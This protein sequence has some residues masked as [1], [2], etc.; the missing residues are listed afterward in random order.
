MSAESV[1]HMYR[2]SVARG[3]FRAHEADEREAW[4]PR[5][6][7]VVTAI[8][9]Y[10]GIGGNHYAFEESCRGMG[11]TPKVLINVEINDLANLTYVQNFGAQTKLRQAS[12]ESIKLAELVKLK[13]DAWLA[14]PPCQPYTRAGLM[15]GSADPR[16]NSFFHLLHV[17][18]TMH[19][20]QRPGLLFVE[21]VKN[22]E[23]S[24]TRDTLV[25]ILSTLG[26]DTR[27]HLVNPNQVG[28]PNSRLRYF[29]IGRR[30]QR[31][32]GHLRMGLIDSRL[33]THE[34]LSCPQRAVPTLAEVLPHIAAEALQECLLTQKQI[35]SNLTRLMDLVFP[36]SRGTMCFTKGYAQYFEGTGSF[37]CDGAASREDAKLLIDAHTAH[38]PARDDGAEVCPLMALRIRRLAPKEI[39]SLMSFPDSFTF[40]PDA[41]LRQQYRLL[42]NSVSVAV[43]TLVIT[44]LLKWE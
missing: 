25:S 19:H 6:D 39:S 13:A 3:E 9:F 27:E 26:Y 38:C 5:A 10:S 12:I 32:D 29:L 11:L 21:N 23:N 44:E 35:C 22:F 16:A 33:R 18:K 28:I 24:D 41:T 15:K 42:G 37:M 2:A 20:S 31:S 40:H 17:L 34:D 14:S 7:G 1:G 8:D 30:M 4:A 36:H 43:V